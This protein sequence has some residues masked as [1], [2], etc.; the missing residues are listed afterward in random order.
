V[1]SLRLRLQELHLLNGILKINILDGYIPS[2]GDTFEIMTCGSRAG[3]FSS[4]ESNIPE[5]D[6]SCQ[7]ILTPALR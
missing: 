4:I 2:P 6:L 7:P 3:T 1:T 5:V